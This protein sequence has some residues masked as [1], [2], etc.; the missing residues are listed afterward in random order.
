M[1][2][3]LPPFVRKLLLLALVAFGLALGVNAF[4][5][6][7]LAVEPARLAEAKSRAPGQGEAEAEEEDLSK[8]GPE[9]QGKVARERARKTRETAAKDKDAPGTLKERAAEGGDEGPIAAADV[10][11]PVVPS[12]DTPAIAEEAGPSGP[13]EMNPLDRAKRGVDYW[14]TPILRRNLFDSA[15]VGVVSTATEGGTPAEEGDCTRRSDLAATV[16]A[17]SVASDPLWSTALLS[18]SGDKARLAVHRTGDEIEGVSIKEILRHVPE[19]DDQGRLTGKRAARVNLLRGG[20]CEYLELGASTTAPAKGDTEKA[21]DGAVSNAPAGK[22]KWEGIKETGPGEYSVEKN[23]LDQALGNLDKLGRE[24]RI[25]PNFQDGATNGF[26]I[27]SIRRDSVAKK[28][29]LANNDILKSV[30]GH[31]LSDTAGAMGLLGKLSSERSFTLEV[32]RDGKPMTLR[33]NVQ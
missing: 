22:G 33:Y 15:A 7:F 20:V 23:T 29:G 32:L 31:D 13:R 1:L 25:V 12:S 8:L 17:V 16:V 9:E 5:A 26:K 10:G 30:N 18:F 3:R 28:L 24:A 4:V 14:K 11:T 19:F 27:F 2:D 21:G 6:R